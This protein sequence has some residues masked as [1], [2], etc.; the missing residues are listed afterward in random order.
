MFSG[1]GRRMTAAASFTN[2]SVCGQ[3]PDAFFGGLVPVSAPVR[4]A[5][6]PPPAAAATG[7]AYTTTNFDDGWTATEQRDWVRAV[8]GGATVLIHHAQPDIRALNNVDEAT[9]HVWNLLVA[10]RYSNAAN[11]W[12][13]RSWWS[14]G[15]AFE[16]K[17]FAEADLTDRATG[18]RVHVALYRGGNGQRWLEFITP[19]RETFHR[20]FT[21][22]NVQDGTSWD[23]LSAVANCNRFAVAPRDLPGKWKSTSGAAI[24]Y[25]N[26]YTGNSMG[27]ASASSTTEITFNPDGSYVSVYRGVDG[28]NG[29]NRYFGE[30]FRG[31]GSVD[32]WEMKLTNR[33]K[34]A[35][36][37]F[38]VQ[39]EAVRGGRILHMRRGNIEELHLF[40]V[41]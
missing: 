12:V 15:G 29:A 25:V 24:E 41:K 2:E 14:D 20:Q 21:V 3:N 11:L 36:D 27:M 26:I 38:A 16:A 37:T 7:F 34:G 28:A 35:T 1:N 18:G 32:R 33:F 6:E 4:P 8:K 39:F 23:K 40:Q 30:T 10:P 9:S 17:H 5:P 31:T 22:V 19:D 13:R